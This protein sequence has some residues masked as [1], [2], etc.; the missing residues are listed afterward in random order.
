[1]DPARGTVLVVGTVMTP[2]AGSVTGPVA[3]SVTVSAQVAVGVQE[4]RL[5][6]LTAGNEER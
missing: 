3:A 1:M 4:R 2:A 5:T 6:T